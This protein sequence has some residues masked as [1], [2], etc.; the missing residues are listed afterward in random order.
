[1]E[2]FEREVIEK[3]AILETK[4]EMVLNEVKAKKGITTMDKVMYG[5]LITIISALVNILAKVVPGI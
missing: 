5:G 4:M 3:I 2:N 1:M